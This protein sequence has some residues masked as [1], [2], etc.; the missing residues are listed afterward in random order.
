MM[1]WRQTILSQYDQSPRLVA[2]LDAVNQWFSLDA[3]FENFYDTIWNI[4]TAVGYGLDVWGRILNI[5][6]QL[7]LTIEESYFGFQEAG[8]RTGFNQGPFWT[9]IVATKGSVFTLADEPYRR[10]LL[11]KAAY[12]ITDG[13]VP[14][15]NALMMNL[16]PNRGN[17]FVRDGPTPSVQWFG[18]Q[19]AGDRT[20]FNQAPFGDL[21]SSWSVMSMSYVF[22]FPLQPFEQAMVQ[23]GVLP[24]PTG[25]LAT[26]VYEAQ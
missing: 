2:L 18:F 26:W 19:E 23:S 7:T 20:G 3:N 10:L 9:G 14:A 8:D 5:Q 15:T 21:S 11:A 22:M 16:F 13:S 4:D 12:N 1:N 17:C 25:V 6:R 24:R